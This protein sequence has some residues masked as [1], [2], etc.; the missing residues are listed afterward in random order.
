MK[1][2]MLRVGI[3]TGSGGIH[4]PL[5]KD[6][7]FEFIPIPDKFGIGRCTYG[8]TKGRM[9]RKLVDYFPEGHRVK[10]ED[11]SLHTDPEF[12]TFTYGDPTAPKSILRR[13]EAGDMLV[14][15]CGLQGWDHESEPALYLAGYF[16]VLRA[17]KADEFSTHEIQ[18][19]FGDNF[20]VC[21]KH[22]FE[23]QKNRLILAKGS[24]NSRLLEQA[25]LISAV[26]QDRSGKPLKILSPEMQEIF[27]DF[28]GKVSFQ[29]STP[30]WVAPDRVQK[31]AKFVESLR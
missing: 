8:N 11:R 9:G 13:L 31:A 14:F 25:V 2:V 16:D 26:G 7:S 18:D 4:G 10:M 5:F 20:H 17:G 30:R 6:S 29:R 15:Y 21:H 27:G 3:D 22:V 24:Q 19:L 28:G 23:Q 12:A 1:M